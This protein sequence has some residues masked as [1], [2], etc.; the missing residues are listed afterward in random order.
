ME[1]S[2]QPE[3][4]N[5]FV[6]GGWGAFMGVLLSGKNGQDTNLHNFA[7]ICFGNGQLFQKSVCVGAEKTIFS[8][9][10]CTRLRVP[11]V[12]LHLSRYTCCS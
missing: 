2:K 7:L 8:H 10:S 3:R 9:L 1:T 11:P 12:A 4:N 5:F 6:Q